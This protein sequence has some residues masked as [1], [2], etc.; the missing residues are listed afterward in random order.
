VSTEDKSAEAATEKKIVD[1]PQPSGGQDAEAGEPAT[2][3]TTEEKTEGAAEPET[4]GPPPGS[5]AEVPEKV[6][7][8]SA[9]AAQGDGSTGA[10]GPE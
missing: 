3:E 4:V 9:D 6:V 1:V 2:A 7:E 10:S 8:T 5:P